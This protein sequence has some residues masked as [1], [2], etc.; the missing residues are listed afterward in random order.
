[1]LIERKKYVDK[2][3]SKS[4]NGKVKIITGIRRCGKSFLLRTLYKQTLM[5][6]GVKAGCFIEIDLEK[7][8]FAVYRNP[9]ELAN[10]VREKTK[11]KRSKFYV[12]VDEIQRS[13]KVKTSDLDERL[14]P[15]EDRELLYTTFY[16]TLSSLMAL[17]NV[18]VYVTG[19]NS[20]MLSSDIV[21]NFRDRG[22]EI[23]VYPLSFEE[24]YNFADKEKVEAFEDY[25]TFGGMPLAVLEQDENEKRKYLQDLHKNVYMKDIVE[26][27]KLKDDIILD[28]LTDAIYSS[29][30]SLSNPHKL[31]MTTS[32]LMGRLTTDNTIKGYL[33]YLEDAYLIAS[34]KRWDVKGKR[35]FS[36]IL[37]YYAMDLGLRNARL[38]WRQQER[39]HLMENMLYND[40]IRRGYS[41]DVGVVELDRV[42]NSK[43]QQC[44]YEIDF[45]VNTSQGKVYIQSA[46]NVDTPEKKA[47]ETFS[48]RNTGDFYQ[49]IIVLDGSRKPWIDE[50]GVM[51]VGVIP[52]L[53]DDLSDRI[54]KG[55]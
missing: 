29:V 23:R 18:D 37:K 20:K 46:L 31:S 51:Y 15:E 55:K 16:D 34:A 21:T 22:C 10:Y 5:K 12:F 50:D 19:S 42:V 32:S 11:D 33:N 28:A 49:K 8:E 6:K 26:R 45:V 4:W 54:I 44:Q 38:N 40:L 2:L 1:M 24:F 9:V 7:E 27:H 41:V 36:T 13:F 47:Q 17:P 25:L 52:F 35:Y 30:G 39:S 43:R 53:L 48:L 3:L 14:V